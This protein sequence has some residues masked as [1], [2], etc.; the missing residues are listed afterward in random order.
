V[1]SQ[2]SFLMDHNQIASLV[3]GKREREDA[4]AYLP[5]VTR[6]AL[7][8]AICH[9]DYTQA[10]GSISVAMYD[11]RL[12][13]SNPGGLHFGLTPEALTIPHHSRPWNPLIAGVFYRA[14]IIES[15]GSGTLR[16][17][18]ACGAKGRPAPV[19]E[20]ELDGLCLVLPNPQ[21]TPQV[22]PQV[23][24][25]VT[26]QVTPEV[27]GLVAHCLEP[28]SRE[29]LQALMAMKDIKHFRD[30]Y[31]HP[32]LGAGLIEMTIPDKPNSRLQKYRATAVG[33]RVAA[34]AKPG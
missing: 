22:A 34:K 26:P 16:M 14:G 25:Q 29:E 23:A 33:L 7:A 18:E 30:S 10:S 32:A 11:N 27:L 4:P 5:A 17:I 6:E 24:P 15:W 21:A 9:R 1:G 8:N 2:P 12:E 13:I 20:S 19:W 31:L 28:R 3:T